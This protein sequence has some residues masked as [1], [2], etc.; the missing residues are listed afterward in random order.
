MCREYVNQLTNEQLK[1]IYQLFL[2]DGE[3]ILALDI[4]RDD[5]K[6]TLRGKIEI[7]GLNFL[8]D[9]KIIIDNDYC[10]EVNIYHHRHCEKNTSIYRKYMFETFGLSYALDFLFNDNLVMSEEEE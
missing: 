6:I 1:E 4:Y 8:P 9:E 10:L 5:D 3:K 7:S 2:E